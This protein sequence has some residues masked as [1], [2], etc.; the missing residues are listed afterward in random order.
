MG[1]CVPAPECLAG[2]FA[3]DHYR[4]SIRGPTKDEYVA[5]LALRFLRDRKVEAAL[6]PRRRFLRITSFQMQV[7]KF[8]RHACPLPIFAHSDRHPKSGSKSQAKRKG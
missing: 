7:V 8:D 3:G 6:I 5:G 4:R 1:A 2:L